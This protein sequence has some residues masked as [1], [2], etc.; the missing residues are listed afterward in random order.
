MVPT[1]PSM[2]VQN[3]LNFTPPHHPESPANTALSGLSAARITHGPPDLMY[4]PP[5]VVIDLQLTRRGGGDRDG[6]GRR[7]LQVRLAAHGFTASTARN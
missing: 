2:P 1:A 4:S 3:H 6:G 7:T 5:A